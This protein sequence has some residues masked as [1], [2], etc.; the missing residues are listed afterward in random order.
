M[1]RRTVDIT[2][3]AYDAPG[4]IAVARERERQ[5]D[6]GHADDALP[7]FAHGYDLSPLDLDDIRERNDSGDVS[8]ESLLLEEFEE[9]IYELRGADF[10]PLWIQD[11]DEREEARIQHLRDAATELH[12]LAALALRVA[13]KMQ[14]DL[15]T[16][17]GK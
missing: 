14:R 1:T 10:G 6:L 15:D 12:Q 4:L 16:K 13:S 11:A 7:C 3:D 17:G 2:V 9:S 8:C 5:R